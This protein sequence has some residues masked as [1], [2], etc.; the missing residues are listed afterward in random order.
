MSQLREI[1]E[2]VSIYLGHLIDEYDEVRF[3]GR[4]IHRRYET[5]PFQ[6][7]RPPHGSEHRDA[8]CGKCRRQL[9]VRV[10]SVERTIK[11]RRLRLTLGVLGLLL[12][13][14]C[15]CVV[16]LWPRPIISSDSPVPAFAVAALTGVSALLGG[17]GLIT[18]F[19][20]YGI[21]L[22]SPDD[23]LHEWLGD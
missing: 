17:R 8:H 5:V 1:G 18:G 20:E 14:G 9:T 19:Q 2:D 10:H 4:T 21:Q 23:D 12:T 22:K 11:V 16:L 13:S 6:V 7:H 15:L 3:S